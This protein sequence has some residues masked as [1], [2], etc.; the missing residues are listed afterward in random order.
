MSTLPHSGSKRVV[1][2]KRRLRLERQKV[3]SFREIEELTSEQTQ[4]M[5]AS[6]EIIRSINGKLKTLGVR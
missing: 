2:M 4:A 1:G 5:E 3:A 6:Q